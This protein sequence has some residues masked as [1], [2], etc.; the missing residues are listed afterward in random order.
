MLSSSQLFINTGLTVSCYPQGIT[1]IC[2]SFTFIQGLIPTTS[3]EIE[4]YYSIK[5]NL[6]S[7]QLRGRGGGDRIRG[8]H[9]EKHRRDPYRYKWGAAV[10]L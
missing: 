7:F 4:R 1:Y 3:K 2:K 8:G 9:H 6:I 5:M 10:V